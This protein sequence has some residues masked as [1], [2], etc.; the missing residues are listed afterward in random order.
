MRRIAL[1]SEKGGV[2]KSTAV[3]NLAACLG[4]RGLSVIVL[5]LDPQSNAS[6]VLLRGEKPRRPTIAEVI[7]GGSDLISAAVPSGFP[8]VQV[9]PSDETLADAGMQL[10]NE[11]GR[12]LRLRAALEDLEGVDVV[13]VDTSPTRSLLTVNALAAV[14]EVYV[15]LVPGLFS[16]LGL[17]QLQRDV[18]QVRRFMGN[19]RLRLAGVFLN[20]VD[21][22]SN[23]A[24]DVES[25]LREQLGS[26][27]LATR[28]PRS[29]KVEESHGRFLPVVEYAPRSPAAVAFEALAEEVWDGQRTE[30]GAAVA[31]RDLAADDAA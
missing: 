17:G 31:G 8:S 28:V 16:V 19:P 23:V 27:L 14:D 2:G 9:V 21:G 15:P 30:D 1:L 13:L 25:Q 6:F 24:R 3:L 18:D 11:L 20:L 26:C 12:E 29:T 5:D 10:T 22:R 4:R 7:L